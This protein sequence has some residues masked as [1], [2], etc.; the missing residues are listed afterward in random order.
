MAEHLT[1]SGRAGIIVPEGIIFQSQT[2]YKQL[3]KMLVEDY[4]VAVVSLPAGVFNPYS[5]VKTSILI[6]DKSLAKKTNTIGFFKVENDGF[7]LGAQRREIDKNDLPQV[8]AE[9]GNYLNCLHTGGS[10][11]DCQ[12]TL[13]L[14]VEKKKISENGEFNLSGERYREGAVRDAAF[15]HV[16]LNAFAEIAAGNSAPQG[17]EYFKD[18]EFPFIRTSDVGLVHLSDNFFG[19]ADKVNQKAID[20]LRL[21]LFP[22]GTILFPKSGA[23]TFLNHRVVMGQVAYVSSHLACIICDETKALPKYVYSLLCRMDAR[24]ITPD[25]AYPSLRLSEIGNIQI[26]LP[27]LEV[28]KEIVAEIEGYQKVIIGARAVID[29]YRPHISIDPDW[30]MVAVGDVVEFVSG[31]TVSIPEVEAE[32]GTPILAINNVTEDGK[33]I[34]DGL[35]W[36]KPPT[37]TL[38]FA[39]KGDLLF[40]WRNGSKHLVGKTALFDLDGQYLFASFLLGIRP[41]PDQVDSSYL[42]HTLNIFRREGRYLQFMR[43]NVNGLFNREELKMVKIPLPPLETQ[44]AIVAEIEAEQALVAANREL[45]AR[46]EK[47]IQATLA[48]VW[49]EGA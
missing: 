2:A 20:E 14:I 32:G 9:I 24:Q 8:Q 45:I 25:Q 1:P 44:Q 23:S 13:G 31:L 19:T 30:P 42:W 40:N 15:P 33:L 26:P 41:H 39:Q 21:R 47:K 7:S 46:F 10:V 11:N 4:L 43:Q 16:R 3:R 38:N 35:R 36:I 12:P 34:L 22:P 6:L 18:G 27:P 5:G 48:G 37:K 17:D 28:Q 49:V 29:N